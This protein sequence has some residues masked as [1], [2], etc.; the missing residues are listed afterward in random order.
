MTS[1]LQPE[2]DDENELAARYR[3]VCSAIRETEQQFGRGT[4]SVTLVAVS[5][6]RPADDVRALSTLGHRNFAENKIQEAVSKINQLTDITDLCWHFIG[7]IQSNKCRDIAHHF[8]WVHSVDRI[9]IAR[10]LSEMRPLDR[11]PLNVL[12]QVNL[13]GENTKSGVD[14]AALEDLAR[15]VAAFPN[16]QLR[17]LMAIPEPEQ[18]FDAQRQIFGSLRAL[19]SLL[20]KKSFDLDVLSMGMTGDMRAAIAEGATHVRVGTAIFGP[21][22]Y[23]DT[24]PAS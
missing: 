3:T 20:N 14:P 15:E 13:Q 10:R 6:T 2:P 16:I 22:A 12:L 5:K 17:G 7:S 18:A 9:K 11:A 23:P 4:D 19:Q 8:D 1:A 21:R 24:S